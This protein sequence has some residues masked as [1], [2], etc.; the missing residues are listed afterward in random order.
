MNYI[1][2]RETPADWRTWEPQQ[3]HGLF[4]KK[5][6]A[7]QASALSAYVSFWNRHF[8][9]EFREFRHELKVIA[10]DTFAATGAEVV[11]TLPR[12]ADDDL[13]APTDDDD[14]FPPD[15]FSH[16]SGSPDGYK[17][18]SI[19]IGPVT[20]NPGEPPYSSVYHLRPIDHQIYTN[21]YA[22]TGR[23]IRRLSL[24]AVFDH[25]N[26]EKR[27]RSI[28]RASW[29]PATVHAHLSVANKHPCSVTI[30]DALARRTNY[31]SD[32]RPTLEGYLE[33]LDRIQPLPWLELP[34]ARLR[35][36]LR[37]AL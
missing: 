3:A 36:L 26:A 23:T 35:A 19:R 12:L 28:W 16:L 30:S 24:K 21:S 13:V 9:V 6:Y 10:L 37:Q 20:N 1:L 2:L 7:F 14:W 4:L 31:S 8:R 27:T 11:Q 32:P 33:E 17:W 34:L 25:F 5:H 15:L 18:G 22:V 29:K